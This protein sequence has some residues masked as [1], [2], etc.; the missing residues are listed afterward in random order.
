LEIGLFAWV[1]CSP[2]LAYRFYPMFFVLLKPKPTPTFKM[3]FITLKSSHYASD[4]AELQIRLESFGIRCFLK[5]E[6]SAQVLTHLP[7]AL[8][9]LQ[10]AKEDLDKVKILIEEYG[11]DFLD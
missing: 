5:N 9:E 11:G 2:F 3:E 7:N 8:V 1:L 6:F 10:V 4:L